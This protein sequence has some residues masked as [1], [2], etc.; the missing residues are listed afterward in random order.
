MLLGVYIMVII[1]G[2]YLIKPE[3]DTVGIVFFFLVG[4]ICWSSPMTKVHLWTFGHLKNACLPLQLHSAR[5]VE[6]F[7]AILDF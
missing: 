6:D 4:L 5:K 3:G 7:L 2:K 1:F